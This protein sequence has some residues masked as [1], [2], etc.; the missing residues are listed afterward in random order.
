M[1]LSR[2]SIIVMGVTLL[3]G[4]GQATLQPSP[5]RDEDLAVRGV[6]YHSDT[7]LI[8]R[9]FGRPDSVTRAAWGCPIALCGTG[10]QS[11]STH[12]ATFYFPA[13]T[14]FSVNGQVESFDLKTR[15]VATARGLRVGDAAQKLR[16]I[17]GD[18]CPG[19]RGSNDQAGLYFCFRRGDIG[20][21]GPTPYLYIE[22]WEGRISTIKVGS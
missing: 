14:V 4:C 7:S 2:L 18:A 22:T 20:T 10:H 12:V 11:D 16:A 3:G 17:Y 1:R 6:P 21:G 15:R 8:R 9:A 5:L 13:V 19:A